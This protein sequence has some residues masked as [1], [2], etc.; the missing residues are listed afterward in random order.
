MN[1]NTK[2]QI[3]DAMRN[4]LNEKKEDRRSQDRGRGFDQAR[5]S[6]EGWEPTIHEIEKA[7]G[8]SGNWIDL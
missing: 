7:W 4:A 2:Q 5:L 3:K 8:I 6:L 1:A